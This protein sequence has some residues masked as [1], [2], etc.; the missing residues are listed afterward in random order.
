[1]LV[2][3]NLESLMAERTDRI[4]GLGTRNNSNATNMFDMLHDAN[5]IGFDVKKRPLINSQGHKHSN[6]FELTYV[7]PSTG[8]RIVYDSET[9]QSKFVPIN[10]EEGFLDMG[11]SLIGSGAKP[12]MAGTYN[13]NKLGFCIYEIPVGFS[14][15]GVDD[16]HTVHLMMSMGMVGQK[17]LQI[18]PRIIRLFC[19]NQIP[20]LIASPTSFGKRVSTTVKI[21]HTKNYKYYM[22]LAEETLQITETWVEEIEAIANKLVNVNLTTGQF[23]EIAT[24][25]FTPASVLS[26]QTELDKRAESRREKLVGK[27]EDIFLGNSDTP[28]T[29]ANVRGTAW[30]GY[31]ALTEY[32][33]WHRDGENSKHAVRRT[34]QALG[35]ERTPTTNQKQSILGVIEK[36]V[37]KLPVQL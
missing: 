35:L 34:A 1:M 36:Y 25:V 30:A 10:F 32:L 23:A 14:V 18:E 22:G 15:A 19:A 26:G 7:D 29:L 4:M 21:R 37:E 12:L 33:D 2:A 20:S 13:Q 5:M 8:E 6:L 17:T 24:E 9:A 28:D 11:N 3:N 31:N 27:V 16:P